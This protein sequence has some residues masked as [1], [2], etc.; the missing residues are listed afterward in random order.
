MTAPVRKILL[1]VDVTEAVM[2]EAVEKKCDLIISHHPL[3]FNPC[4]CVGDDAVSR[5]V[6]KAVKNDINI[7]AAHTNFDISSKGMNQA[8]AD[9]FMSTV[10]LSR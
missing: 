5:I 8:F 9:E 7:Y 4:K 6:K 10:R 2:D 1:C 3:L